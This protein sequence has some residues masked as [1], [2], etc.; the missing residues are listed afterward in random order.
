MHK[1]RIIVFWCVC[2]LGG[3]G[4]HVC[5]QC[6]RPD[7]TPGQW[8]LMAKTCVR[9]GTKEIVFTK[10]ELNSRPTLQYMVPRQIE[11]TI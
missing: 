5:A 6:L 11:S 2:V 8:Y 9:H 7:L 4:G 1:L 3:G 10:M